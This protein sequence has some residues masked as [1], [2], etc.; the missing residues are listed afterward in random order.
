[1]LELIVLAQEAITKRALE[2]PSSM[3]PN[4]SLAFLT[5]GVHQWTDAGMSGETTSPMANPS[6]TVITYSSLKHT[7]CDTISQ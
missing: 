5:N 4:A 6:F 3:I 7:V 2:Y 1:M